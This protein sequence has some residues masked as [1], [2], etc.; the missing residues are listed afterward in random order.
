LLEETLADRRA[1]YRQAILNQLRSRT[2]IEVDQA[3]FDAIGPARLRGA[4]PGEG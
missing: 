4:A 1:R 3:R 2:T